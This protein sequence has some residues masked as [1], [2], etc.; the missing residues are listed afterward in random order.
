MRQ[1][2]T[3]RRLALKQGSC[4]VA[5]LMLS[6]FFAK[7]GSAAVNQSS[8]TGFDGQSILWGALDIFQ[9][10]KPHCRILCR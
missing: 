3:N 6:P 2:A 9:M 4:F 1:N 8:F 5:A 10:T 7:L